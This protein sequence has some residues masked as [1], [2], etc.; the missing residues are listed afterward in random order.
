MNGVDMSK[1]VIPKSDQ[2]NAD[3]LIAGPRTI[4]ITKVSGTGNAD[5]PVAVS[6]DGDNGKPYKPG[7]SMRRVM[8]A[9]WGVDAADYVGRRMTIY[10]DPSVMFGGMKVGGVRISHMSDIP[11]DLTMALTATKGKRAP[12]VV[13]RLVADAP[14][15]SNKERMFAS[16]RA[17]AGKGVE[18][19]AAFRKGLQPAA[20][21]ALAP[22]LDELIQ[23]ASAVAGDP[24]RDPETGEVGG[25][26]GVEDDDVRI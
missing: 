8:I 13:K 2:L 3:D 6:F 16:A 12:F 18:A 17:A 15:V 5:Q 26:G 20:A 22:I 10:C 11:S 19:L 21:E 14:K 24:P 23:T 1:F 9:A 4:T 25:Q 7:K